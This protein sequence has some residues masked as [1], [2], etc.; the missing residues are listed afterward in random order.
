MY[1]YTF[2]V[3][4]ANRVVIT[5]VGEM[6]LPRL[7]EPVNAGDGEHFTAADRIVLYTDGVI[8]TCN[9]RD[10]MFGI[11]GV[12]S[13]VHTAKDSGRSAQLSE[14]LLREVQR[15]R[16]GPPEDDTLIVELSR[17]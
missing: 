9:D 8:E 5:G 10:Q 14:T 16:A 13:L 2:I 1:V 7:G 12:R 6:M 4:E 15:F 3:R 11:D 17:M